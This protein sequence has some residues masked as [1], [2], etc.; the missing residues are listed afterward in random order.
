[1]YC[2]LAPTDPPALIWV[3]TAAV[4]TTHRPLSGRPDARPSQTEASTTIVA[5]TQ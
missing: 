2:R 4:S 1:M 5:R 3:T